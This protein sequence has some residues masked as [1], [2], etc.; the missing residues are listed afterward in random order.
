ML[1]TIPEELQLEVARFL[2][3]PSDCASLSLAVPRGLGLAALQHRDV[4]QYKDI[5]VSVALR[6]LTGELQ[7]DV[8]LMLR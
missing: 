8:A 2:T 7:I 6:L 1:L 3:D 5:L 4:P